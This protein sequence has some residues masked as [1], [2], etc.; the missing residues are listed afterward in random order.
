MATLKLSP[1]LEDCSFFLEA[2]TARFAIARIDCR[3]APPTSVNNFEWA[4]IN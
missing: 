4:C 2:V 3:A 1:F